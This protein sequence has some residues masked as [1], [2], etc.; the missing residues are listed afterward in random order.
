M[1]ENESVRSCISCL[2][3]GFTETAIKLC[4]LQGEEERQLITFA[5]VFSRQVSHLDWQ[6]VLRYIRCFVGGDLKALEYIMPCLW[7]VV[8]QDRQA[9]DDEL[10]LMYCYFLRSCRN[11]RKENAKL[12]EKRQLGYDDITSANSLPSSIEGDDD[13]SEG[14]IKSSSE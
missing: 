6:I 10:I 13:G 7:R 4:H 12:G 14:D 5:F 1:Y 11:E 8:L 3:K 2:V 9:D